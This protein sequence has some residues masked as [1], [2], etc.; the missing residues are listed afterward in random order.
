[1]GCGSAHVSRCQFLI[2]AAVEPAE[3]IGVERR[4][5]G[6]LR[7]LLREAEVSGP[8]LGARVRGTAVAEVADQLLGVF[9]GWGAQWLLQTVQAP[10][11]VPGGAPPNPRHGDCARPAPLSQL[12][13][14]TYSAA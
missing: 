10:L 12:L 8:V 5:P 9:S 6:Q 4:L 13:H 7:K 1:M 3:R 11:P 14:P 2:E